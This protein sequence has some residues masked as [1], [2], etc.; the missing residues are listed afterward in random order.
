MSREVVAVGIAFWAT[1]CVA[2]STV[3]AET[4]NPGAHTWTKEFAGQPLDLTGYDLSFSDE[5]DADTITG[6][7]GQGPWF[8]PGRASYGSATFDPPNGSTYTIDGGV[9]KI[10]ATRGVN[11]EWHTG[12]VQTVDPSGKGFA[13]RYGYFEAR[14]KVPA[15]PG[16]WCAFWLKSQAEHWDRSIVRTEIDVVEWYGGDPTGHHRA[17]HLWPPWPEFRTPDRLSEHWYL[18]NFSRHKELAGNWHTYGALITPEWVT[19]YLDR[20]EIGRFPTL[21]EFKTRLYP[22]VSLT[23]HE[24]EVDQAI[25]PFA[26]EVDYVRVYAIST[27][28][29]STLVGSPELSLSAAVSYCR[30]SNRLRASARVPL[31]AEESKRG[32]IE[33]H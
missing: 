32:C 25:P 28:G 3:H 33:T 2:S 26:L 23:L 6:N 14:M 4:Q 20:Q 13:Q 8:A 10:R 27:R 7:S 5:F 1:L 12:S 11:G 30:S 24:K 18:G 21:E 22:L 15:M 29:V 31:F 9:M 16:A 19:V 17:V